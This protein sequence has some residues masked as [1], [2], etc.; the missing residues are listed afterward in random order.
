[1]KKSTKKITFTYS[2]WDGKSYHG[3]PRTEFYYTTETRPGQKFVKRYI[4]RYKTYAF[5]LVREDKL[6]PI[7]NVPT[8]E[9][10]FDYTKEELA[11]QMSV[12]A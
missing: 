8:T 9:F 12:I 7:S 2:G 5:C 3:E 11:R 6:H 1:M 10:S 4:A